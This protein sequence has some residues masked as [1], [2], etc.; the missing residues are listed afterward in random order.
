MLFEDGIGTAGAGGSGAA[1]PAAAGTGSPAAP[2]AAGSAAAPPAAPP[3]IDWATAPQQLRTEY[4]NQK[5]EAARLK[6]EGEKW[7]KLGDYDQVSQL[8]TSFNQRLSTAM[9]QGKALGYTEESI[10]AAMLED[11]KGTLA[12]LQTE[13]AAPAQTTQAEIDRRVRE[14][15]ESEVKPIKE[16]MDATVTNEAQSLYE[17][18]RDRLYKAEFGDGLPDANK[19]EL[20]EI[21]DALVSADQAALTRLKFH[22]QTSDIARH[23]TEAKTVFFKRHNEYIAHERKRT[24]G[25]PPPGKPKDGGGNGSE[26][27]GGKSLKIGGTVKDFIANL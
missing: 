14:M 22:K 24:G 12:R 5:A 26:G 16:R 17:T 9:T 7:G 13:Y 23:M 3:V 18:E 25:N 8:H 1:P 19:E 4:E 21:L 20:F 6:A 15:L 11:P 10:R 27:Y 2:P